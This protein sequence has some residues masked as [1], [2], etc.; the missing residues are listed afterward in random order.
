MFVIRVILDIIRME[1]GLML[2]SKPQQATVLP[3]ATMRS[4][5]EP[6]SNRLSAPRARLVL[7]E[8]PS[9]PQPRREIMW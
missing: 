5:L 8:H 7:Q 9:A 4:Q 3:A 6:Q 2:V 1:Q